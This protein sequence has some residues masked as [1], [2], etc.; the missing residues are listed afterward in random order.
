MRKLIDG[1]TTDQGKVRHLWFSETPKFLEPPKIVSHR[2]M[3][4]IFI[5]FKY[6]IF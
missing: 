6:E 3:M 5:T 1:C 2:P 4:D